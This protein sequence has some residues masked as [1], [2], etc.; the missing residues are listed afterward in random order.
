MSQP[1]IQ[2]ATPPPRSQWDFGASLAGWSLVSAG[3]KTL[4]GSSRLS[5]AT[6]LGLS[7]V[8]SASASG[9]VPVVSPNLQAGCRAI[10]ALIQRASAVAGGPKAIPAPQMEWLKSQARGL[11]KKFQKAN[12]HCKV[13]R[14]STRSQVGEEW[15]LPDAPMEIFPFCEP[16]DL[17]EEE[18][19]TSIVASP[20]AAAAAAADDDDFGG[21]FETGMGMSPYQNPL[22]CR[23]EDH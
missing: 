20:A 16:P 13:G 6:G 4:L 17:G 14:P 15:V 1:I 22:N 23:E 18:K 11:E 12:R 2:K 7:R 5:P 19:R 9:L 8:P 3:L 21:G 10:Q